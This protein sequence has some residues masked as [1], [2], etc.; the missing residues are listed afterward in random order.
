MNADGTQDNITPTLSVVD[1]KTSDVALNNYNKT[2]GSTSSTSWIVSFDYYF[3]YGTSLNITY[4]SKLI[5]LTILGP[6]ILS[7]YN[8]TSG[9]VTVRISNWSDTSSGIRTISTITVS[10]PQAAITATATCLLYWQ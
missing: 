6:V 5:N 7:T 4:D 9:I 3:D 10:N 2:V 8:T 1:I